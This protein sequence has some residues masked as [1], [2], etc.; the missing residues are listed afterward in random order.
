M[1]VPWVRVV[2]QIGDLID[3]NKNLFWGGVV[4]KAK[5]T[6]L[7]VG[8]FCSW[9]VFALFPAVYTEQVI[10]SA[11]LSLSRWSYRKA[12]LD[13]ERVFRKLWR[14]S[15]DSCAYQNVS[16]TP[17]LKWRN[18]AKG[19]VQNDRTR[20]QLGTP[21]GLH[22]SHLNWVNAWVQFVLYLPKFSEF[23]PLAE[24]SLAPFVEFVEQYVWSQKEGRSLCLMD[25]SRLLIC[26]SMHHI[27]MRDDNFGA[28]CRSF[29]MLMFPRGVDGLGL[30]LQDSV[31]FHPEWVLEEALVSHLFQRGK[32]PVEMIVA[33]DKK[34]GREKPLVKKQLCL[35]QGKYLYDLDALI[36]RRVD[37]F[38]SCFVAYVRV[39]GDWYQCEDETIRWVSSRTLSVPL[40]RGVLFHYKQVVLDLFRN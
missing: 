38:R 16:V 26:L 12:R 35:G 27:Q 39:G 4:K 22:G 32:A 21:I 7:V 29:F 9:N 1:R 6:R 5:I 28:L 25:S 40:S 2:C 19:S 34:G 8:S 36:E 17:S 11:V 14:S 31:L 23:I 33:L 30:F 10:L 13:R 24:K 3:Q 20:Y 37:G 18:Y 15:G